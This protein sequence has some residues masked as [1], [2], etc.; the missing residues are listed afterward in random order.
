MVTHLLFAND[1]S[2]MSND[3]TNVQTML[4]KLRAYA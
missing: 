4:N 3:H 2:L 1:L